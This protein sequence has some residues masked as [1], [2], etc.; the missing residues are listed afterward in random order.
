M[1]DLEE[2]VKRKEEADKKEAALK[3]KVC[4]PGNACRSS[5]RQ[6]S[7]LEIKQMPLVPRLSLVLHFSIFKPISDMALHSICQLK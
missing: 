6:G 3:A 2:L 5:L 7:A 4:D 1:K